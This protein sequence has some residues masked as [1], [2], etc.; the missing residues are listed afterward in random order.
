MNALITPDR[1]ALA[2]YVARL[3]LRAADPDETG[4]ARRLAL[5]LDKIRTGEPVVVTGRTV[6]QDVSPDIPGVVAHAW[7]YLRPDGAL[8]YLR[9]YKGVHDAPPFAEVTS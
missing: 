1:P 6:F 9:E 8:E 2:E 4:Y 3:R 5:V 7:Y